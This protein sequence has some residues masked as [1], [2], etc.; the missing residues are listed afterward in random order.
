MLRD[1]LVSISDTT[2][3]L[4]AQQHAA[5]LATSCNAHLCGVAIVHQLSLPASVLDIAA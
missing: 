4:A 2:Q 3:G 5:S 1:L